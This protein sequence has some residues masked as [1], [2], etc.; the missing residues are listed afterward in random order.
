MLKSAEIKA[1]YDR[2][3]RAHFSRHYFFPE[4]MSFAASDALFPAP[5][6]A[7]ILGPEFEGQCRMLCYGTYPSWD[8]VQG[9][10]AALRHAL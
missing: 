7:A 2:I 9:R 6:L 8:E 1:D 3:S 10:F 5:D 4:G